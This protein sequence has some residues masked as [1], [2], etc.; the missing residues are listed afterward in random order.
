VKYECAATRSPLRSTVPFPAAKTELN[1]TSSTAGRSRL[2]STA[3][4]FERSG[5]GQLAG[6]HDRDGVREPL[7]LVHVVSRQ[8]D[9]LPQLAQVGDRAPGRARS[10]P[11][12]RRC[13]YGQVRTTA[14]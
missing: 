3:R 11:G 2:N 9:R 13:E 12:R 6:A 8:E 4:R 5:R 7:C 10:V 1:M 14:P